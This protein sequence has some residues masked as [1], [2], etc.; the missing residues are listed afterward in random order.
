MLDDHFTLR[1]L[2]LAGFA[3]LRVTAGR[4]SFELPA[5][6]P[7]AAHHSTTVVRMPSEVADRLVAAQARLRQRDRAHYYYPP[8]TMH[9]TVS[10]LDHAARDLVAQLPS[11]LEGFRPFEVAVYGLGVSP[12]TVFAQALPEDSAVRELRA[13][14][15]VLAPRPASLRLLDMLIRNVAFVN[16]V[17][18]SGSVSA[19]LLAEVAYM[20]KRPFGRF[21]VG[22]VE[23]VRT[24]RLLSDAGTQALGVARAR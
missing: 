11:V 15:S 18:F 4:R 14:L 17:R 16:I 8:Q 22:Q 19:G 23:V 20:R 13:R 1:L 7:E 24:D 5:W 9:F 21:S 2:W 3:R 6:G 10:N 12:T